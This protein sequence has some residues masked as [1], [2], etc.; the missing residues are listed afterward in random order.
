VQLQVT[1]LGFRDSGRYPVSVKVFGF[2]RWINSPVLGFDSRVSDF[3]FRTG[4]WVSFR[5][6]SERE[7]L[8]LPAVIQVQEVH[9]EKRLRPG[10]GV[11]G[12]GGWDEVLVPAAVR[13]QGL[14]LRVEG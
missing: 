8:G 9:R 4:F 2:P 1:G 11:R 13:V 3:G 7:G 6:P 14:G 5:V 12:E 10:Q